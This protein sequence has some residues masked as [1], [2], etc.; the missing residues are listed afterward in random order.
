MWNK[1]RIFLLCLLGAWV[2]LAQTAPTAYTVRT[3]AGSASGGDNG[4]ATNAG[5][6]FPNA[7]AFDVNGNLS[8]ADR[9]N[10]SVRIVNSGGIIQTFAG[11]GVSGFSGDG[12]PANQA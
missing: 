7:V 10:S 12:G 5:L 9:G 4:P 2:G 1:Y 8:I 11:T 6:G 3:F